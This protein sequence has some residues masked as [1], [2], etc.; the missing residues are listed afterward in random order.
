MPAMTSGATAPGITEGN[1]CFFRVINDNIA[2]E[3]YIAQYTY[4]IL[5]HETATIVFED[6]SYG[7]SLRNAFIQTFESLGGEVIRVDPISNTDNLEAMQNQLLQAT[8][9]PPMSFSLPLLKHQ[10]WRC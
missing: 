8:Q 10:A 6:N 4:V 7:T 3:E 9:K 1:D 5:G 2:Q